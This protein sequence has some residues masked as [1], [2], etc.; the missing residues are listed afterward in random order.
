MNLTVQR[1]SKKSQVLMAQKQYEQALGFAYDCSDII[2][3]CLKKG[4]GTTT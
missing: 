2:S 1:L 4:V 3:C